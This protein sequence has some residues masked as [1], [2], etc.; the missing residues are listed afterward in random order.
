ML[1]HDINGSS[2]RAHAKHPLR[3]ICTWHNDAL[4]CMDYVFSWIC[5]ADEKGVWPSIAPEKSVRALL[6]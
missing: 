6:L 1:T 3:P 4:K 2:A 5:E